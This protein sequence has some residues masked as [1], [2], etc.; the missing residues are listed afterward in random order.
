MGMM[1]FAVAEK[2]EN[3]LVVQLG[4]KSST[5]TTKTRNIKQNYAFSR[6]NLVKKL[7]Q[8]LIMQIAFHGGSP[9]KEGIKEKPRQTTT[10]MVSN[11]LQSETEKNKRF[12]PPSREIFFL[13]EKAAA[14]AV[15]AC[16]VAI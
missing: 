1:A 14:V 16:I 12:S 8:R 4:V 11:S 3:N 10:S 5:D 6:L 2:R 13:Y 7:F 9:K 15:A